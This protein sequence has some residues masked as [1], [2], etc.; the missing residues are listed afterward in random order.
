MRILRIA[1]AVLTMA[2]VGVALVPPAGAGP[3]P[4]SLVAYRAKILVP[5]G[6]VSSVSPWELLCRVRPSRGTCRL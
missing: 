2:T 4:T 3:A 5:T 1:V 6:G